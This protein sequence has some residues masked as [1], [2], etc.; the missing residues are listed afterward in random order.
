MKVVIKGTPK[1][2]A[3]L[4]VALQGQLSEEVVT[5]YKHIVES[6]VNFITRV[7]DGKVTSETEIAVL[8]EVVKAL[9][10]ITDHF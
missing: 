10:E 9:A 8:P 3:D 5:L 1:E 6:L 4:V 2:I 7:S